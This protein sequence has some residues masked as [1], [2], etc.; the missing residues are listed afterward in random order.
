MPRWKFAARFGAASTSVPGVAF[1][2]TLPK[3]SKIAHEFSIV[4]TLVGMENR[5]ESFQ[6]YT[7]RPGGRSEDN[8]PAGGWP[9][10][11]SVVSSVSGLARRRGGALRRRVAQ[12][13]LPP[14]QQRGLH[15]ACGKVSWPG[16]TG[17]AAR[18]VRAGRRREV[19]PGA[20]R[21]QPGE[22]QRPPSA[23]GGARAYQHRLHPDGLEKFQQQAFDILTSSRLADALDLEKEDPKVRERYGASQETFPGYGGAPKTR[24]DCCWLGGLSKPACAA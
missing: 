12:D 5:H 10:L 20:Q 7:G 23:V 16:F 9:S 8:E 14:V 2:E 11:G 22:A 21:C 15:D 24:S 19:G 13:E 4:R 17:S 3:L 18:A 6:C 1:C